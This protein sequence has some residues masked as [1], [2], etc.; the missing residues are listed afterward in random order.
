MLLVGAAEG[1]HLLLTVSRARR[2]PP[3]TTT[4]RH[5]HRGGTESYGARRGPD[6]GAETGVPGVTGAPGGSRAELAGCYRVEGGVSRCYR[7]GV[8]GVTGCPR[9]GGGS[10]S[11]GRYRVPGAPGRGEV[12]GRTV[13]HRGR[14]SSRCYR[15]SSR[16]YR[17]SRRPPPQLFV[18]EQR[19]EAV[20]R[21]LLFLLLALEA[22]G[23]SGPAGTGGP[24]GL[25]PPPPAP[26]P[27]VPVSTPP[28]QLAL[29][30]SW[31]FWAPS[32]SA[33]PPPRC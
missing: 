26:I 16:C 12:P 15:G 6:S 30:P 9:A 10:R 4:V 1:R 29:P 27:V 33:P 11:W 23:R 3:R 13:V 32:V 20:A 31:N 7:E 14:G 8:P 2:G 24:P 25:P 21:Q 28:P 5:R 17:E 19:P 18:A 22:P